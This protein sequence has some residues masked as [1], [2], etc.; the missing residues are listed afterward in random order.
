MEHGRTSITKRWVAVAGTA[1]VLVVAGLG[2]GAVAA[3]SAG[4]E[5]AIPGVEA[6]G[7]T[8]GGHPLKDAL[9]G[10]VAD[11][12]LTRAQADKVYESLGAKAKAGRAQR[13]ELRKEWAEKVGTV[14]GE[15]ADELTAD[16]K[17]GKTLAQIGEVH[18]K[19]QQQVIDAL[20]GLVKGRLDELVGSGQLTQPQADAI[21]GRAISRLTAAV[22]K[23]L[24]HLGAGHPFLRRLLGRAGGATGAATAPAPS[25]TTTS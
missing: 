20:V 6:V 17:A 12:T 10:L 2:V 24:P 5:V 9:D 15:G 11:G 3:S 23:Q 14:V 21:L 16:L 25:T 19:T 8:G 4:A 1:G 18:G 13:A 7:A 22:D